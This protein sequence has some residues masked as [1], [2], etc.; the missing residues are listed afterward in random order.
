MLFLFPAT[1]DAYANHWR[2]YGRH[3]AKNASRRCGQKPFCPL[4]NH[5]IVNTGFNSGASVLE[6]VFSLLLI[7]HV[8]QVLQNVLA[9]LIVHVL[10]DNPL[11][12]SVLTLSSLMMISGTSAMLLGEPNCKLNTKVHDSAHHLRAFAGFFMG[13]VSNSLVIAA[14]GITGMAF[15]I[16]FTSGEKTISIKLDFR[17]PPK[18][19]FCVLQEYCGRGK[20]LIEF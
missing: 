7:Q 12:G 8:V 2:K 3:Y 19:L 16:I 5:A 9:L 18:R 1:F 15:C 4:L 11:R 17:N 20:R 14:A 13:T 6:I 10:F